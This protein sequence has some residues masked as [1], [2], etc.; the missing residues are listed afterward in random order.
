MW[1]FR[2][3]KKN[4]Q[5]LKKFYFKVAFNKC[6][7]TKASSLKYSCFNGLC[8]IN[9]DDSRKFAYKTVLQQQA[10]PPKQKRTHALDLLNDDTNDTL[11]G[12]QFKKALVA[13]YLIHGGGYAFI[14]R[15][16]NNAQSCTM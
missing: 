1:P 6:S 14:N 9:L 10:K 8:G 2:S 11:D 3:E 13:D 7:L 15:R 16:L 4:E 12:F 5:P